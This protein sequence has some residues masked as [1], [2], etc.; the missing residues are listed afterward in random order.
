M[1]LSSAHVYLTYP[2]V[3][4]WSMLEAMSC[5]C[6]VVGSR[7]APVEEVLEHERNGL[8]VDFF[9][10]E[11]VAAAVVRA[12]EDKA[13]M[14]PLREAARRTVQ[15]RYDLK[16]VCLPKQAGLVAWLQKELDRGQG[17]V[18]VED[19]DALQPDAQPAGRGDEAVPGRRRVAL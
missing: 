6:L 10:P 7:T 2:F 5:G 8:L 18:R 3:L 11:E 9:S 16:R 13:A 14:Q 12:L 19:V 17:G 4:S 1:S 15:E